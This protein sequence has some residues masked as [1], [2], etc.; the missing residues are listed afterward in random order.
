MTK[1]PWP[2]IICE[3]C[4]SEFNVEPVGD[5]ETVE[6]LYCPYCGEELDKDMKLDELTFDD[7]NFD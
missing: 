6:V 3:S 2:H 7:T 4:N 1:R 5:T